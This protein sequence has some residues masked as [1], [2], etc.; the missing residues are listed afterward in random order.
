MTTTEK[1]LSTTKERRTEW[2]RLLIEAA[3]EIP[4][5]GH[6]A[7]W[8]GLLLLM[9]HEGPELASPSNKW[10]ARRLRWHGVAR[11][12]GM[13]YREIVIHSLAA[14]KFANDADGR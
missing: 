14:M 4:V 8:E 2:I 12:S 1:V 7:L 6:P 9:E 11:N 3:T 10:W 5:P 13:A